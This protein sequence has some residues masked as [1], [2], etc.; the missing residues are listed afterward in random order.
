MRGAQAEALDPKLSAIQVLENAAPNANTQDVK[1]LLG[2]M[3]FSGSSA[4][5]K[6]R[7]GDTGKGQYK[8][9]SSKRLSVNDLC[10][11]SLIEN[12]SNSGLKFNTRTLDDQKEKKDN[13][14][15]ETDNNKRFIV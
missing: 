1:A 7:E 15:D 13:G 8:V 2:R 5:K 6:V 11:Y 14:R 9:L 4:H 3:L 12:T 10:F